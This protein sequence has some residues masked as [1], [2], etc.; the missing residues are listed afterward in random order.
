MGVEQLSTLPNRRSW[1]GRDRITADRRTPRELGISLLSS[2]R[3][4]P[5]AQNGLGWATRD[6]VE[7]HGFSRADNQR[8]LGPRADAAQPP[9]IRITPG[10]PS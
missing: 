3:T 2:T 5:P 4:S 10:A 9:L 1:C 7:G 6:Y 8:A